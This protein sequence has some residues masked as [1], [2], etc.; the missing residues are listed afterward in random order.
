[1]RTLGMAAL[2]VFMPI[3]ASAEPRFE[4]FIDGET[5]IIYEQGYAELI[6]HNIRIVGGVPGECVPR[7]MFDNI[8]ADI[9]ED[10]Y[11]YCD[12]HFPESGV[13]SVVYAG[14]YTDPGRVFVENEGDFE[15]LRLMNAQ[16]G[17][18]GD[19]QW[20]K[21]Y[22]DGAGGFYR[23]AEDATAVEPS[24]WGEIKVRWVE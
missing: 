22:A 17:Q 1:M 10:L 11:R 19:A 7:L 16:G 24:S 5:R 3:T 6:L 8:T 23:V 20:A 21:W 15:A 13:F 18:I 4:G 2:L 12:D 9:S 14:F